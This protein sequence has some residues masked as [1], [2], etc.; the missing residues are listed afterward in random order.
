[1]PNPEFQYEVVIRWSNED[2]AYVAAAPDL[3]GCMADGT[4]YA[5][6]VENL[7]SVMRLWIETALE[8]GRALPEPKALLSST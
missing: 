8:L 2:Q 4:T 3:P 1:M 6:A 5:E 7:E